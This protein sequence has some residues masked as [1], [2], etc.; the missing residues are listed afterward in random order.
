MEISIRILTWVPRPAPFDTFNVPSLYCLLFRRKSIFK[1]NKLFTFNSSENIPYRARGNIYLFIFYCSGSLRR[2]G[3]KASRW[4]RPSTHEN[5]LI[6][7]QPT[8]DRRGWRGGLKALDMQLS[9]KLLPTS[10]HYLLLTSESIFFRAAN[11]VVRHRNLKLSPLSKFCLSN[12]NPFD[13]FYYPLKTFSF[14]DFYLYPEYRFNRFPNRCFLF[15][16]IV[17]SFSSLCGNIF[18]E[19][20]MNYW[21]TLKLIFRGKF[22]ARS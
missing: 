2:A 5:R 1:S 21:I 8:A 7:Q 16:F 6:W 10:W 18:Y 19:K 17:V 9:V 11:N 20:R 15:H 3:R 14:T 4:L 22:A 12:A 13:K